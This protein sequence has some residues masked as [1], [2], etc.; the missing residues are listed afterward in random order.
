V[1]T[2]VFFLGIDAAFDRIAGIEWILIA[3]IIS[4]NVEL[5]RLYIFGFV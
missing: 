4:A 2:A 5:L 1:I 3:G